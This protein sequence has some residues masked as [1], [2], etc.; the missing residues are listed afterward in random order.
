MQCIRVRAQHGAIPPQVNIEVGTGAAQLR[1]R[2]Q[3]ED[4]VGYNIFSTILLL[5]GFAP[6]G[7]VLINRFHYCFLYL[8][9]L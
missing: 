8:K 6:P 9:L 3:A 5:S 7:R 4:I 1:P 2:A